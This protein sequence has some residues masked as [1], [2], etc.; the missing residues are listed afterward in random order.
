MADNTTLY[1][2]PL[3]GCG[4]ATC[5][6]TWSLDLGVKPTNVAAAPGADTVLVTRG[7]DLV[8]VDRATGMVGWTAPLGTTAPGVAIAGGT[9]YVGA[10]TTLSTF[11]VAGCGTATCAPTATATL[12]SAATA[13]PVVAGGVVYVGETDTVEAFA[14]GTLDP[15]AAVTVAGT[16]TNLSVDSGRL[17]VT[18]RPGTTAPTK[19]TAF[20]PTE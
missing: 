11:P 2:F 6:A 13:S 4:A 10:G 20:T 8:A 14:A 5:P 12:A 19:L 17:F 9:V 15:L 7:T 18:S 16:T 1:A 3:A